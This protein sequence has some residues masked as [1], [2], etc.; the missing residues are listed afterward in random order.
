MSDRV[1]STSVYKIA[2]SMINWEELSLPLGLTQSETE[3]IKRDYRRDYNQQKIAVLHKWIEKNG[4]NAT[5]DRLIEIVSPISRE[6]GESIES[7][8]SSTMAKHSTQ[9]SVKNDNKL[10][11]LMIVKISQKIISWEDIAIPLGLTR[12]EIEVIKRNNRGDYN[13][14][15]IQL[16]FKWREKGGSAAT[17]HKLVQLLL[18]YEEHNELA[19]DIRKLCDT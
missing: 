19:D 2:R 1:S 7:T 6:L 8:S 4:C 13:G 15:K 16:L 12:P 10:S 14:Q 5:Y 3:T 18:E 9:P 17:G 11:D